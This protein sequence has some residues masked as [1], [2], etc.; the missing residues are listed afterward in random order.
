[1]SNSSFKKFKCGSILRGEETGLP[2]EN[3]RSQVEIDNN[4][5]YMQHFVVEA[6][7]LMSVGFPMCV[8]C[9][10]SRFASLANECNLSLVV[11]A[12]YI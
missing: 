12:S 1:M 2:G 5:A 8:S 10:P 3:P 11:K 9:R 7:G 4:S 6:E